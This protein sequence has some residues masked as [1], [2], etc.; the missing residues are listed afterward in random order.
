MDYF[1]MDP[2][3]LRHPPEDI[4]ISSLQVEPY[5]DGRKIHVLLQL[6][7]FQKP[8]CIELTLLDPSGEEIGTAS[9]I[10]PSRW[11]QEITMHIKNSDT[12][13]EFSLS[14]SLFYPDKEVQDIQSIIFKILKAP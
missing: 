3:E 12:I 9:I 14:A 6:T 1:N 8:P 5:P 13:G 7:P 4:R 11:K 10:E 2:N